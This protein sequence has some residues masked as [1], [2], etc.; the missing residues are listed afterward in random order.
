[1]Y[2]VYGLFAKFSWCDHG[3][4][5]RFRILHYPKIL[6]QLPV[7]FAVDVTE[8]FP[9]DNVNFRFFQQFLLHIP[10]NGD[11]GNAFQL[12]V[13]LDRLRVILFLHCADNIIEMGVVPFDY[14]SNSC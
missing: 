11:M 5:A 7:E 3:F 2:D 12:Q 10:L 9:A 14:G 8:E 13:A 1:V 6:R 4:P